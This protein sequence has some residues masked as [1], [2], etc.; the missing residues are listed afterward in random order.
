[1]SLAFS[2]VGVG[3]V[4]LMPWLQTVIGA[5]GWRAACW[6]MGIVMLVLL[7]PLNLLLRLR[8]LDIGLEPDGDR[9]SSGAAAGRGAD[10][11]LGRHRLDARTRR[12]HVALLVDRSRLLLRPVR[13]WY[14]VQVHCGIGSCGGSVRVWTVMSR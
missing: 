3:S 14:A 7:V 5:A 10:S 4:V 13:A 8:P 9:A 2:G 12:A 6:T 1:M 11:R